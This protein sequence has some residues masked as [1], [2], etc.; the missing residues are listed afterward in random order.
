MLGILVISM[1]MELGMTFVTE[2]YEGVEL[3]LNYDGM[4]G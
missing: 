3:I 1:F 4:G 2:Y